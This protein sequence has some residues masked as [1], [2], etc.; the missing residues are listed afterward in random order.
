[1]KPFLMVFLLCFLNTSLV[2]AADS[3]FPGKEHILSSPSRTYELIWR[4]REKEDVGHHLLF[5]QKGEIEPHE[6]FEF[7]NE[8]CVHWSPDERHFSISHH[9]G[10]NIA[11]DYIFESGNISHRINVTDL[12]PQD[13]S[14]YFRK[15]ILHGYIETVAWNTDGLFI[16]VFGDRE[17]SPRS[18][19]VTL[20]CIMEQNLWTC[21]KKGE[22]PA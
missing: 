14:N 18:F 22:Q 19:D 17:D 9:I 1:M 13:V 3:C 6:F 2:F 8:A 20:Q 21:R 10:S 7:Y 15:G 11:E 16:R 5:R 12:L 4:N